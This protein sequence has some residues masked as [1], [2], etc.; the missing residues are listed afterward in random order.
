[1]CRGYFIS[2][3]ASQVGASTLSS[4]LTLPHTSHDFSRG[5]LPPSSKQQ[6]VN[7]LAHVG[8]IFEYGV[9]DNTYYG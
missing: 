8:V 1:M 3:R 7:Q 5:F 6:I 9:V 4:F 2:E